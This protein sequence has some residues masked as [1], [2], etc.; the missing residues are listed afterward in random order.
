ML[1]SVHFTV[2]IV[3]S[4]FILTLLAPEQAH[5]GYLDPGSGSTLVQTVIA[6]TA[7]FKRFWRRLFSIFTRAGS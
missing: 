2:C 6:A 7:A 4:A 1:Q 5:A 3:L